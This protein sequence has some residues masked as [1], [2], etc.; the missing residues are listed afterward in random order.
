VRFYTDLSGEYVRE[1]MTWDS[2]VAAGITLKNAKHSEHAQ[3]NSDISLIRNHVGAKLSMHQFVKIQCC[4]SQDYDD[5]FVYEH[6]GHFS[7]S[8]IKMTMMAKLCIVNESIKLLTPCP[9]SSCHESFLPYFYSNGHCKSLASHLKDSRLTDL[10]KKT[11]RFFTI[12]NQLEVTVKMTG[13]K[14]YITV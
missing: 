5:L 1:I 6:S 12:L 2:E 7:Y 3:I 9:K 13:P 14:G 8:S 11:R 4:G 10:F